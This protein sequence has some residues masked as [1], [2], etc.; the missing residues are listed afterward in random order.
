ML[1]QSG[2]RTYTPSL[3]SPGVAHIHGVQSIAFQE[4]NV[5]LNA[6]SFAISIIADFYIKT[7]GRSNLGYTWENFPLISASPALKLRTLALNCLTTYYSELWEESWQD[8]YTQDSWSKP[9]DPRLTSNFF[10]QL[11]PKW[12]RNNALRTDYDRRQALVEID[13]LAAKALGLTLDELITIYRVQFP[14]MQQYE[15][16]TYYDMNGRIIFTTSKGLT[17]VGLP[18]KGNQKKQTIGWEDVQ[19]MKTGTV[20]VTVEDDTL[21]EGIIQRQIIYQAPFAKC[22]RVEDY[23]TAWNYFQNQI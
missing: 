12:Q 17:G 14:V 8:T 3:V 18:R 5:L 2:E 20:E 23:R 1:S 6:A 4:T 10:T 22:D 11:T 21:P 9:E 7:T 16:E 19:D 15:R 13:V